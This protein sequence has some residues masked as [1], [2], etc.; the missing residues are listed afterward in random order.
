M[1]AFCKKVKWTGPICHWMDATYISRHI[2]CDRYDSS[3]SEIVTEDFTRPR[4]RILVMSHS[5]HTSRM[6]AAYES[7]SSSVMTVAMVT[8]FPSSLLSLLPGS[9]ARPARTDRPCC[10]LSLGPGWN[11]KSRLS[12]KV[13][14]PL[15]FLPSLD[16]PAAYIGGS[17][18]HTARDKHTHTLCC[19]ETLG[20]SILTGV[21]V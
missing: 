4:T 5:L 19:I 17:H 14:S 16:V 21:N 7:S 11:V 13:C 1:H 12:E 9:S 10:T 8:T 18:S 2:I 20:I 6:L 15:R 3:T